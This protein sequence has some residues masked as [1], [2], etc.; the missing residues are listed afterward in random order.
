MNEVNKESV[1]GSPKRPL[2]RQECRQIEKATE[3]AMQK[4]NQ[5]CERFA[6]F[7]YDTDNLD[8]DKVKAKK[9]E[10]NAKWRLYAKDHRLTSTSETMFIEYC[11]KF[12]EAYKAELRGEASDSSEG[13][14]ATE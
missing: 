11:E 2:T 13:K 12:Y 3:A 1:N 7:I 9:I 14:V 6:D 10:L 4:F 8:D 5:F